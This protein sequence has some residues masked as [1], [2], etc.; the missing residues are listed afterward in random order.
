MMR[1]ADTGDETR[2]DVSCGVLYGTLRDSAYKL[3]QLAEQ[4]VRIHQSAGIWDVTRD[5][6]E[7]LRPRSSG[8]RG[9]AMRQRRGPTQ[10]RS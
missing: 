8:T 9:T 4:E 7:A 5:Q 1:L 3:R 2:E 10:E 6:R